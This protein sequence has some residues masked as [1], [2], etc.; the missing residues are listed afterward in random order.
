MAVATSTALTVAAIASAAGAGY[1]AYSAERG[2]SLQRQA[3]RR[4][5]NAQREATRIQLIERQRA[6]L[7]AAQAARPSASA[8]LNENP[9]DAATTDLTGGIERDRL[10]L[11]RTSRL[12]G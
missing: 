2:N 4:Q 3:R 11:M 10:R 5:E 1:G 12:G 8:A 9:I 6:E 7:A